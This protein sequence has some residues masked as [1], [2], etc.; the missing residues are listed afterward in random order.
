MKH[1]EIRT[2]DEDDKEKSSRD[3]EQQPKRRRRRTGTAAESSGAWESEETKALRKGLGMD[4]EE[5]DALRPEEATEVDVECKVCNDEEGLGQSVVI[6]GEEGR[7]SVGIRAPQKVSKEQREEHERTHT[8][9]RGWCPYCVKGRGR[10][11]PHMRTK[12][13][14]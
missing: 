6:E 2:M 14:R 1:E 11:T 13:E 9:Y 4:D 10:N 8:P 12:G 7:T 3:E 5:E